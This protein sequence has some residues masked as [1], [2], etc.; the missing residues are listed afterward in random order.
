[1]KT[2]SQPLVKWKNS[3][4]SYWRKSCL[5]SRLRRKAASCSTATRRPDCG[6]EMWVYFEKIMCIVQRRFDCNDDRNAHHFAESTK[7][8]SCWRYRSVSFKYQQHASKLTTSNQA[9]SFW[10]KFITNAKFIK[11]NRGSATAFRLS[12]AF[13]CNQLRRERKRGRFRLFDQRGSS[14]TI[15]FLRRLSFCD[16]RNVKSTTTADNREANFL[17]RLACRGFAK[18]NFRIWCSWNIAIMCLIK[19]EKTQSCKWSVPL[20]VTQWRLN[21]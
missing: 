5:L 13:L 10:V 9:T 7:F 12:S 1:M 11:Q 17:I 2:S 20:P 16:E 14:Q 3:I 15:A 21:F 8:N 6:L 4:L 18:P 19:A